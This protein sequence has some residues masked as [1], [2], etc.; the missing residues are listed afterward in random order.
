MPATAAAQGKVALVTGAASG[1]GRAA[2]QAFAAAGAKVVVADVHA[3]SGNET[4]RLIAEAGGEASFVRADVSRAHEVDAMVQHAVRTWGRLDYALNNAGIAEARVPLADMTEEIWDHTLGINL[5]GVWMCMKYEIRQMASQ[6]GGAIVNMSSAVGLVGARR[7]AA[8]VASKHGVIGLTKAAALE[9]ANVGIR[10]NAICP[11]GIRTPALASF[12]KSNP[13]LESRLVARYPLGR[14]GMPEEVGAAAVWL[15][16]DAAA[17]I[18]GHA[19]VMDGG[20][21]AQ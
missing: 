10:V 19:L 20:A 12:I 13:Q 2:A 18:T 8:Y 3:L 9:Y 15:C 5:K 17:F 6:G 16:S 14:F 1:I 7:Q 4:V 21:V 11:G